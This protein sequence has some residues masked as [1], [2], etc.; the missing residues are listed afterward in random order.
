MFIG[1][2]LLPG[3]LGERDGQVLIGTVQQQVDGRDRDLAPARPGGRRVGNLLQQ[4]RLGLLGGGRVLVL[5]EGVDGAGGDEPG[6]LLVGVA[7]VRAAG[8]TARVPASSRSSRALRTT[9]P[10]Q[11]VQHAV[12]QEPETPSRFSSD[13]H[14]HPLRGL[15]AP[16]FHSNH[17]CDSCAIEWAI[18]CAIGYAVYWR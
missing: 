15:P 3:L 12:Q 10:G 8:P 9:A 14:E 6:Q 16:A 4:R 5:A 17:A 18:Q 11:S 7:A 1:G 13:L 2:R